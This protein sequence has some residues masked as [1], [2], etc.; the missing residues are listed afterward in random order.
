MIYFSIKY[1]ESKGIDTFEGEVDPGE[2]LR[3]KSVKWDPLTFLCRYETLGKEVFETEQE[4]ILAGVKKLE[5]IQVQLRAKEAKVA[6]LIKDLQ[7]RLK[8]AE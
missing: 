8:S 2:P 4:A 7:K 1:L 6:T 5:R 3:V